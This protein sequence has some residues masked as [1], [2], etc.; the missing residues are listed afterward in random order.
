[1]PWLGL[2]MPQ[3][4]PAGLRIDRLRELLDVLGGMR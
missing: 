4:I 1:M 3:S 2:A